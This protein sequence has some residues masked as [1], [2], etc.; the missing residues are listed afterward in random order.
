MRDLTLTKAVTLEINRA[1]WM[2]V[3]LFYLSMF[4]TNKHCRIVAHTRPWWIWAVTIE[5]KNLAFRG[6]EK[7][8]S[9]FALSLFW[10]LLLC[11]VILA[12]LFYEF[13]INCCLSVCY[14]FI[15]VIIS[16]FP[17]FFYSYILFF[18]REFVH[19]FIHNSFDIYSY[20]YIYIRHG[21]DFMI[22]LYV[23]S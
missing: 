22:F 4:A 11:L 7:K 18:V 8:N 12:I 1:K 14:V 2:Q 16:F 17:S 23:F 20:I 13:I 5:K 10:T 15:N 6:T 21:Y 3:S 9:I 19:L